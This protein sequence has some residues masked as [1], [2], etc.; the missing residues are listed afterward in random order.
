M[1]CL[2]LLDNIS[3]QYVTC[4]LRAYHL[5]FEG[6]GGGGGWEDLTKKAL[7]SLYSKKT[8]NKKQKNTGQ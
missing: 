6:G 5:T 7:Y 1:V 4:L 8:K 2:A 3:I